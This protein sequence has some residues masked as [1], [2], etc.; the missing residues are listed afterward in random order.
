MHRHLRALD[1][2]GQPYTVM[3]H[4][5]QTWAPIREN[6]KLG[7]DEI[8]VW[9]A[10][11]N[12]EESVLQQIRTVLSAE[13]QERAERFVFPHDRS[14]FA[15]TRGILRKLLAGYL[16]RSP[17]QVEFAYGHRGKPMLTRESTPN[18]VEFNVSHSHDLA[19]LAFSRGRA[20]GVDIQLIRPEFATLE[21]AKHYFSPLEIEEL[22]RLPE[23]DWVQAFF[24]CWTR[25][26]AY[27]KARGDGFGIPPESVRV[28]FL[29]G[30]LEVLTSSDSARWKL[31]SLQPGP[32]YVGA[33]V[34]EGKRWK[35]RLWD[36]TP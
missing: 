28:S 30:E 35:L 5:I 13:E 14:R 12:F 4:A 21:I 18:R 20:L 23:S 29:P 33:L 10:H 19:L 15:V 22:K 1:A 2:P 7:V 31:L 27:L 26:E 34:G 16:N 25:K 3:M 36:W 32:N 24:T 11:L 17:E 9:R 8:H 6:L